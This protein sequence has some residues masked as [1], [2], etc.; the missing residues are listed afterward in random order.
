LQIDPQ[1]PAPA[2]EVEELCRRFGR[3]WVLRGVT[4]RLERGEA[5]AVLG[6][7]GSGKTTLLRLLATVLRPHRG[8]ARIF[9]RDL[10]RE[11][12]AVRGLVGVLGHAAGLYEDLTAEENLRFAALMQGLKPEPARLRRVLEEVA[13]ADVTER[14]RAYSAGMRRRLALARLLLSPPRLLLLD[15]PYASFDADGVARVNAF[16]AE[17]VAGGGAAIIATH[18]PERAG[19]VV[20]SVLLLDQGRLEP[21]TDWGRRGTVPGGGLAVDGGG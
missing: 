9:G 12:P 20:D 14:V 5:V 4:L 18:D 16:V 17:T 6:R 15:E 8:A 3:H 2:V 7:N 19:G 21:L 1:L 13:L 10:V 11:A